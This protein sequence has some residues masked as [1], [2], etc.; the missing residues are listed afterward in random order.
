MSYNGTEHSVATDGDVINIFLVHFSYSVDGEFREEDG[1]VRPYFSL[2]AARG[3]ASW[4]RGQAF[5]PNGWGKLPNYGENVSPDTRI[6]AFGEG[7]W[8]FDMEADSNGNSNP[9]A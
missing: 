9:E 4:H 2:K 5:R 7:S 1:F 6:F 8:L 3:A